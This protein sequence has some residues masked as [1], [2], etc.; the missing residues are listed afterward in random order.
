MHPNIK[1]KE[2]EMQK[3][4][5]GPRRKRL[6]Y[7]TRAKIEFDP[8]LYRRR[9]MMMEAIF[10]AEESD[11]HNL[12]TRFRK[13]EENRSRWGIIIIII[14][15]MGWN[16]KILNRTKCTKMLGMEVMSII[17]NY[18]TTSTCTKCINKAWPQMH[19]VARN[20]KHF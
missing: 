12:R 4:P 16:L 1:Q 9:G 6:H 5:K 14:L 7:R 18:E 11:E 15:A 19:P 2:E 3:G 8:S 13:E 17:R 20:A 10:G